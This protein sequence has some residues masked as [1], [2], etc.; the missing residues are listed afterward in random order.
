MVQARRCSGGK[1]E[2]KTSIAVWIGIAGG[3]W[4][5]STHPASCLSIAFQVNSKRMSGV[6]LRE[7][8]FAA[9]VLSAA[10]IALGIGAS[11]LATRFLKSMLF[12]IAPSD[13]ATLSVAA[14][15]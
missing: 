11:F 9:R 3:A 8:V 15:R 2:V 5:V 7:L 14:C 12:G 6:L 13:P 1:L 4:T 10:A